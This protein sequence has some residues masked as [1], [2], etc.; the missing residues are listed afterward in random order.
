MAVITSTTTGNFSDGAT[1]VGGVVPGVGDDAVAATGTIVTIDTDVTVI[2]FQQAGTGKFVLGDNRTVSGN[3]ITNAGTFASG[4]TV[5][6]TAGVGTTAT[7]NGNVTGVSTTTSNTAGIVVTGVG[8]LVL[9]GTVTGSAGNGTSEANGSAAV[10]TD[11]NSTINVNGNV[12]GGTGNHKRGIQGG[13][14]SNVVL[15]VTNT[16][17]IQS[18]SG[19]NAYAIFGAGTSPNI[20]LTTATLSPGSGTSSHAVQVTGSSPT[21]TVTA[22]TINAG[23]TN[24]I[25]V[26]IN[27][28]TASLT[29]TAT[30][31]E[32][33]TGSGAV[34][35]GLSGANATSNLTVTTLRGGTGNG[36]HGFSLSG[37]SGVLTVT[38]DVQGGSGASAY[39]INA[40]GASTTVTI[41]GSATAVSTLSHAIFSSA[42]ANGVIFQG[43][44][45]D[46]LNGAKAIYA[47]IFRITATN[48]GTTTYTNTVG[49]PTGT[50][51]T[52]VSPD[53]VTGMPATTDVRDATVYGYNSE[54]TGTMSV[55]SASN[56]RLGV[57]VDNTTGTGALDVGTIIAVTGAQVAAASS[58]PSVV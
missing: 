1:W 57:A 53:L 56:V 31:V 38:G 43:N 26:N 48:S 54:L 41:N 32:G 17:S 45:T 19:Q 47:R 11:V 35:I 15:T 55:P 44:L 36:A 40:T 33:G 10:Y 8:T 20:N 12:A 49:Y 46:S 21:V 9:N 24:Q 42:T 23:A 58:N 2:S 7:I 16:G 14:S 52:R 51:V 50:P 25:G 18:G 30:T 28:I 22:T 5:E 6:V 29:V 13:S 39:G 37:S 34:G 3:V 4:G 27:G